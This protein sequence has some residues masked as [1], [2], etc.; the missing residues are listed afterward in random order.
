MQ[1][2]D[3]G[4]VLLGRPRAGVALSP[5]R[6]KNLNRTLWNHGDELDRAGLF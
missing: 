3:I 6:D 4:S 5:L 2:S 1:R